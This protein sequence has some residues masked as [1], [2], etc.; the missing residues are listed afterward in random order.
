ML[1]LSIDRSTLAMQEVVDWI[2]RRLPRQ[3]ESQTCDHAAPRLGRRGPSASPELAAREAVLVTLRDGDLHATGRYSSTPAAPSELPQYGRKWIMHSGR[4][5]H[6]KVELWCAGSY[7]WEQDAL[8]LADGQFID[9]RV[10]R[11]LVSALWPCPSHSAGPDGGYTN[12]YLQL[13]RLAVEELGITVERQPKKE[14]LIAWFRQR[15]SDQLEIS[16]NLVRHLATFVR[17]PEAQR[18]GNSPWRRPAA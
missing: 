12:P 6:I 2:L 7:C 5:S 13:M 9:V 11:T 1:T 17:L 8:E 16:E 14:Q 3:S 18:G 10:P 15:T 4:P